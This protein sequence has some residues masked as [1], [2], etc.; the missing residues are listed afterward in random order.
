LVNFDVDLLDSLGLGGLSAEAKDALLQSLSRQ[1]EHYFEQAIFAELTPAQIAE[2]QAITSNA[3]AEVG[4]EWLGRA[5]PN[6][7][8]VLDSVFESMLRAISA[9]VPE[10]L[11]TERFVGH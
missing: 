7:S 8:L 5:V 10:I 3:S 11:A 2:Y 1:L 4:A 6:A 9:A